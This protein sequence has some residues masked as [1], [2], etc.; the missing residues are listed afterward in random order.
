WLEQIEQQ[1]A[2]Q[3]QAPGGG[4]EGSPGE[5]D[6]MR[7]VELGPPPTPGQPTIQGELVAPGAA[8]P[9]DADPDLPIPPSAPTAQDGDRPIVHQPAAAKPEPDLAIP[10]QEATARVRP[11]WKPLW[12]AGPLALLLIPVSLLAKAACPVTCPAAAV[13]FA[14]AGPLERPSPTT[15]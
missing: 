5:Q 9:V 10:A 8:S 12:M 1:Q 13:P 15:G 7:S 6:L 11:A 2:E 4:G 14:P 3:Q